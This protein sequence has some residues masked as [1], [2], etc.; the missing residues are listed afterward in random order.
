MDSRIFDELSAMRMVLNKEYKMY[1]TTSIKKITKKELIKE[2][3]DGFDKYC[4]SIHKWMKKCE[5]NGMTYYYDKEYNIKAY[6]WHIILD[7]VNNRN[8]NN[9][10][11]KTR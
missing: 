5:D 2:L 3:K 1:K 8:I 7:L 4:Q 6:D 11:T 9:L 10:L